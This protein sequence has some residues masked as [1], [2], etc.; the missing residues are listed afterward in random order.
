MIFN[1]HKTPDEGYVM[2]EAEICYI[3]NEIN[4]HWKTSFL[5]CFF[6]GQSRRWMMQQEFLKHAQDY[7][8]HNASV[9]LEDACNNYCF[10]CA[11]YNGKKYCRTMGIKTSLTTNRYFCKY[12]KNKGDK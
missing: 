6:T 5:Y 2:S 8:Y 9:I 3:L 4:N 10:E 11:N 12:F 7:K 1:H